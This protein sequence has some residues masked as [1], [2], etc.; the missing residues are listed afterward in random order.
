R[1]LYVGP[2]DRR[3]DHRNHT[4][5][6]PVLNVENVRDHAVKILRPQVATVSTVDELS[7][8]SQSVAG[9]P[10]ATFE[11]VAHTE[12]PRHIAHIDGA[13]FVHKR[14]IPG[15]HGEGSE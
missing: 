15:Y 14:R 1:T 13:T 2:L 4:F 9:A 5:G 10:H 8:H 7:R 12:L 3:L 11:D 6:D